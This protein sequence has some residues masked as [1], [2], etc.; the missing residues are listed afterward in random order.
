V[1]VRQEILSRKLSFE[2]AGLAYG[3]DSLPD[4]PR[5]EDLDALPPHIAAAV[6]SL[7]P[8]SVSAPLPFESSVLLFLLERADDPSAFMLRRREN[9]RRELSLVKAQAAEDKL[10]RE[11]RAAT[12]VKRHTSELPFAYVAEDVPSR[13]R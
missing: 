3:A 4:A 10:L 9:A 12:P 2:E 13:A 8:G 7:R 5:D 1:R 6:K 11:L